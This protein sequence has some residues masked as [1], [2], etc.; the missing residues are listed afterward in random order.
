MVRKVV[1]L[2]L[3]LAPLI[4]ALQVGIEGNPDYGVNL[5]SLDTP[6][7]CSCT[8]Y[9]GDFD[10]ELNTTSNV[11]FWNVTVLNDL[12]VNNNSFYL[13]T[14]H[15]TSNAG[16]IQVVTGN[17]T[18]DYLKGSGAELTDINASNTNMTEVVI[19]NSTLTN[20]TVEG[21]RTLANNV[22][23][24]DLQVRDNIRVNYSNSV[25]TDVYTL[26]TNNSRIESSASGLFNFFDLAGFKSPW[27]TQ[28][29]RDDDGSDYMGI[30][31]RDDYASMDFTGIAGNT[32]PIVFDE[33][34]VGF[35]RE[36]TSEAMETN[37]NLWFTTAGGGV[38]FG[39]NKESRIFHLGDNSYWA[40]NDFD[41]S[42]GCIVETAGMIYD[43]N[44]N[45]FQEW[46]ST[47]SSTDGYR[48]WLGATKIWDF[49][50]NMSIE[51]NLRVGNEI[52]VTGNITMPSP[53]GTWYNCGV[54]NG[55]TWECT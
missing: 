6:G 39:A 28:V 3:L 51:N 30:L 20:V 9:T 32:S 5:G 31:V 49:N 43:T 26:S 21:Y 54:Q 14:A 1:I 37:G 16:N 38:K 40:C 2:M 33:S 23:D 25:Y 55:G 45:T 34:K 12:W 24:D 41:S 47:P 10:Q 46:I 53:D 17:I 13:G 18:A 35:G 42:D 44:I 52:N 7:N 22:F 36:P 8:I 29:V 19:E 4:S 27:W 15:L 50:E 11:T 48:K